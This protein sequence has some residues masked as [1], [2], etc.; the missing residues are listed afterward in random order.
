MTNEKLVLR[1]I[2]T[3]VFGVEGGSA[4]SSGYVNPII[5]NRQIEAFAKQ[6]IVIAPLGVQNTELMGKP[7]VTLNVSVDAAITAASLSDTDSISIQQLSY[8]QVQVTPKE[9]GGAFQITRKEMDRAFA[10]ILNEK[11]SSA[12]YALAKVKDDTIYAALVSGATTTKYSNQVAAATDIASSDVFET[13]LIADGI[14][15]LRVLN[16]DPVYL[17]IHPYQENALLK[18][19]QFIDASQYGGREVVMNGEIGKY[20]GLRVFSSNVC[21]SVGVSTA[22]TDI[23]YKALLLGPRA[24]VHAQKRNPTIDSKYEPLDRAF[25]VA[26]VE[27]WGASVLNANEICVLVGYYT[28]G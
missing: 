10:N 18:D 16:R 21:T 13:D 12:G 25:T 1:A 24:F 2:D 14:S 19:T 11:A 22:G 5:W 28:A 6:N 17:V 15:A 9:Y 3:A 27:D 23:G 8:T 7:G 26:Y 20:L 4:T